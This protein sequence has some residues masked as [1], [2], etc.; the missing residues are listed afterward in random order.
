MATV[1]GVTFAMPGGTGHAVVDL[2][3]GRH[4]A[5]CFI[6]EGTTAEVFEQMMAAEG[7][8]PEGSMPMGS[9]AVMPE[10]SMAPRDRWR[11]RV[12]WHPTARPPRA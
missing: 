11:P 2:T 12:R 6:P 1:V 8:M 7:S 9:M 4:I 3:P 5:V 10:G